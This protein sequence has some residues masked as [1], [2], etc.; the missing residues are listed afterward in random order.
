MAC[1]ATEGVACLEYPT[2]QKLKQKPISAAVFREIDLTNAQK[3]LVKLAAEKARSYCLWH[4]KNGVQISEDRSKRGRGTDSAKQTYKCR[5]GKLQLHKSSTD[6]YICN[7]DGLMG[8]EDSP[9]LH[10]HELNRI[11]LA[12]PFFDRP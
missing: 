9:N 2:A 7:D 6:C 1:E 12:P 11:V 8:R 5:W 3:E 10:G 4:M